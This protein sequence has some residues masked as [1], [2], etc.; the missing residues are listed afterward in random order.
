[1]DGGE[2]DDL[3]LVATTVV[4]MEALEL[5]EAALDLVVAAVD[6]AVVVVQAATVGAG[7]DEGAVAEFDR[8]PASGGLISGA[9]HDEIGSAGGWS[10]PAQ[11]FVA[12]GRIAPLTRWERDDQHHEVVGNQGVPLGRQAVERAPNRLSPPLL[13]APDPGMC[14]WMIALSSDSAS[15][16]SSTSNSH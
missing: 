1:M 12:A 5:A 13:R 8:Q 3:E 16:S 2:E 11:Q 6:P 10:E 15:A 9:V 7:R 14:R 4:S